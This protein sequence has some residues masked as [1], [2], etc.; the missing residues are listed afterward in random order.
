MIAMP[1]IANS[2]PISRPILMLIG[3]LHPRLMEYHNLSKSEY[4]LSTIRPAAHN[5]YAESECVYVKVNVYNEGRTQN[6]HINIF[7]L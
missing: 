7:S 2:R 3:H 4:E 6:L 1:R 5:L